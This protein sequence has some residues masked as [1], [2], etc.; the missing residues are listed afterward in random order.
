MFLENVNLQDREGDGDDIN[1][2]ICE[3]GIGRN[4]LRTQSSGELQFYL[5]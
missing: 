3:D 1:E 4:W 2:M 5:C